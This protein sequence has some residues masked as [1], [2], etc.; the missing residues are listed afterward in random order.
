[1]KIALMQPYL[2]PYIGY[3]Q[4]VSAVEVFVFYDDANY[5]RQGYINRNTILLN[6][7]QHLFSWPVSNQSSFRS[8]RDHKVAVDGLRILRTMDQAYRRARYW[9]EARGR[10]AR[11]LNM[12]AGASVADIAI[13][14][15][16]EAAAHAQ[17]T[18]RFERSSALDYD[19]AASATVKILQICHQLG[20]T[21]YINSIGGRNLYTE[22]DF[23]AGNLK[24]RY[25][26]PT[27][28]PYPQ[29]VDPFVPSLSVI[30]AMAHIS[31]Q[32]FAAELALGKLLSPT[33]ADSER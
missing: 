2:F 14:S 12:G 27:L 22:G 15:V 9:A 19:R 5:I 6:G 29:G 18:T 16:R 1:M 17:L 32:Q 20:G 21:E 11:V 26:M 4:L 31:P 3:L 7:A 28:R 30:D 33:E 13:E 10:I 8:V 24:L 25:L 23:L